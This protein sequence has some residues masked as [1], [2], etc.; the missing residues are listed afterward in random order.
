MSSTGVSLPPRSERHGQRWQ[1]NEPPTVPDGWTRAFVLSDRDS[2]R[3]SLVV[4]LTCIDEI[5]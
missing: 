1:S 4:F 2:Q 5:L 3:R